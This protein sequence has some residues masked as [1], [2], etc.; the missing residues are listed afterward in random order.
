MVPDIA[1]PQE[2]AF[3]VALT[4]ALEAVSEEL[5]HA[6]AGPLAQLSKEVHGAL[7]ELQIKHKIRSMSASSRYS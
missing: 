5:H 4:A 7:A 1:V 2:E 3:D 6:P